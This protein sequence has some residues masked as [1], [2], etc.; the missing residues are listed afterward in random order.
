[1]SNKYNNLLKIKLSLFLNYL[2]NSIKT[3]IR[4]VQ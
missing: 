4:L 1:V 2:K 3:Y